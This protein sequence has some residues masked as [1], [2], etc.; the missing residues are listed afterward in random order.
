MKGI[1]VPQNVQAGVFRLAIDHQARSDTCWNQASL[2]EVGMLD[3]PAGVGGEPGPCNRP[4]TPR[5]V[6]PWQWS[7]SSCELPWLCC[8]TFR[9]SGGALRLGD[10]RATNSG[11]RTLNIQT[12]GTIERTE[13][14]IVLVQAGRMAQ[15]KKS[16]HL[17]AL[18]FAHN[19]LDCVLRG[20]AHL[21]KELPH[22][23]VENVP[24]PCPSPS[25]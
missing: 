21:L 2:H 16:V 1:E 20:D 25:P 19:L 4:P 13:R 7:M 12:K 23:H 18:L 11:Y 6:R 14:S 24:H 3:N 15:S 10:S 22:R 5:A 8:R 9:F 17:L